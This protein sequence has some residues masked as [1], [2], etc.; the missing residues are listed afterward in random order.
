[1]SRAVEP[2]SVGNQVQPTR[3]PVMTTDS[4]GATVPGHNISPNIALSSKLTLPLIQPQISRAASIIL[5]Q[6]MPD[7][8]SITNMVSA[9]TSLIT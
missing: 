3:K 7:P 4:T 9:S 8:S 2:S 1:M 5:T 6:A